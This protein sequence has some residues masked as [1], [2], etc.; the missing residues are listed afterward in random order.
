MDVVG[1]TSIE[2]GLSVLANQRIDAVISDIAIGST[3]GFSFLREV[4]RRYPALYCV[5][6]SGFPTPENIRALRE[7][8]NVVRFVTKPWAAPVLLSAV[9][10]ALKRT[11]TKEKTIV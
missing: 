5:I 11:S 9:N 10:E 1:V 8:D 6:L 2:A 3:D 4:K 7:F